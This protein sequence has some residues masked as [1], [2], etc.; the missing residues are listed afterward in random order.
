MVCDWGMSEALGPLALGKREEHIFLGREIA[1]HRDYSEET[2][3][4]IDA[5]IKNLIMD[6]YN[7]ASKLLKQNLDRLHALANAL[8]DKE[9]LDSQE[10]EEIV[11][12]S[13]SKPL[14]SEVDGEATE[15]ASLMAG[16]A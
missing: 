5:E 11:N 8:L 10:I 9:T 12:G 1:Q 2:A 7:Q 14:K 15:A 13:T 16:P 3:R 6:S 4:K